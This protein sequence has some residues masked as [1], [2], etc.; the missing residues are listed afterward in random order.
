M[1]FTRPRSAPAAMRRGTIVRA[2]WS[3]PESTIALP[4]GARAGR[5]ASPPGSGPPR[6][7]AAITESAVRLLPSLGSP[8]KSVSIPSGMRRCQSHSIRSGAISL[9]EI[10]SAFGLGSKSTSAGASPVRIWLILDNWLA[11]YA[12]RRR[13]S[14]C[15]STLDAPIGSIKEC[16]LVIEAIA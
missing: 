14:S 11:S 2:R 1:I 6:V 12:A 4:Q 3:S 8:E 10:I 15:R 7:T 13:I 9:A 5:S 16:L